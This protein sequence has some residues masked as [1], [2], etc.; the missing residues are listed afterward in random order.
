MQTSR[1]RVTA[2][3][4][5]VGLLVL[6]QGHVVPADAQI[7]AP[8]RQC[9]CPALTKVITFYD[10]ATIPGGIGISSGTYTRVDGFAYI[11]IFVEFEQNGPDEDP[12]SLGVVFAFD[13]AGLGG[14]RRYFN[15]E[16]NFSGAAHPQMI[17]LSG[18]NSWHGSPHNKSSYT[19]RLPVMGPYVQVFPFNQWAKD[20]KFSIRAYLT[21]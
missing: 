1:A 9:G 13:S 7:A 17:T 12:V 4:F 3:L 15:F 8:P 20:R 16:Q 11:N 5:A 18:E 10:N 19:A 6:A 21:Y 2:R 14:S